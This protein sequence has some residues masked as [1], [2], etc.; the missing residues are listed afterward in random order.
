MPDLTSWLNAAGFA[1]VRTYIQSGNVVLEHDGRDDL[2]VRIED[3][4]R[5]HAGFEVPVVIRTKDEINR[6]VARNPFPG[7]PATQL[8]VAFLAAPPDRATI[9]AI[10]KDAF[11]PEEFAVRGRDVF[12]H[13]PNGMGN[14]K[15]P[16]KLKF[17]VAATVRNW[18]TVVALAALSN[19]VR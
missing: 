13:L 10:R 5:A 12:L 11:V 14:A 2:A 19:D 15:M 8:H 4:L 18:N 3:V 16:A 9:K 7:T 6:V 17:L 1:N